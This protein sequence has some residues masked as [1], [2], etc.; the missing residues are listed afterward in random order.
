MDST[1][2][3]GK[4][5]LTLNQ[6]LHKKILPNVQS[7]P[8]LVRLETMS[9]CPVT[10]HVRKE[11]GTLLAAASFDAVVETMKSLLRFLFARLNKPNFL[12]CFK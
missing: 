4:P 12:Y 1:T 9:V 10:C 2:A 7:K 6:P 11:T 5:L 3:L 8:V